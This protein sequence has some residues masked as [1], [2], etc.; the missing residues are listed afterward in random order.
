VAPGFDP[1]NL[2][3]TEENGSIEY[4]LDVTLRP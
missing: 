1:P 2:V 3:V 4:D